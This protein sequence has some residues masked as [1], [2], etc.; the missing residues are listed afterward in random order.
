M[1]F[2]CRQ[3]SF[4]KWELMQRLTY[5]RPGWEVVGHDDIRWVRMPNSWEEIGTCRVTEAARA[6]AWRAPTAWGLTMPQNALEAASAA[7]RP[8]GTGHALICRCVHGRS[9]GTVSA[10]ITT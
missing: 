8:A 9:L 10:G 4:S 2:M 1:C 6:S 3:S 7:A 5:I